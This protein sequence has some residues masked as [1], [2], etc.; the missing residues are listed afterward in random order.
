MNVPILN[1]LNVAHKHVVGDEPH[2]RAA[3]AEA[4]CLTYVVLMGWVGC[5]ATARKWLTRNSYLVTLTPLSDA[6]SLD[7][8]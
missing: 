8:C 6:L 1:S 3:V 2:A 4:S 7:H 5:R